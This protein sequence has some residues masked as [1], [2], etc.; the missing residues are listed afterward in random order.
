VATTY[1]RRCS[2]CGQFVA[3][4]DREA[5]LEAQRWQW[6][7]ALV[8]EA[9][10]DR[11]LCVDRDPFGA[12]QWQRAAEAGEM[13]PEL[14]WLIAAE[15]ERKQ[16]AGRPEW[17]VFTSTSIVVLGRAGRSVAMARRGPAS[18]SVQAAEGRAHGQLPASDSGRSPP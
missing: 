7:E 2:L 14:R 18:A 11:H 5:M 1:N 9:L 6:S 17:A 16:A 3:A 10:V 8:D 13:V 12:R 4:G 15:L